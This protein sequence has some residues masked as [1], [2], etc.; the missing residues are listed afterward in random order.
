MSSSAATTGTGGK[1]FVVGERVAD[2]EN[3]RAT[4]RYV[5][6]V[7]GYQ[8]QWIGV[9]WDAPGRGKHDGTAKVSAQI[10]FPSS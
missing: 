10:S 1:S 2:Q 5:G 8:G 4:V 3:H 6:E 9:E 7:E